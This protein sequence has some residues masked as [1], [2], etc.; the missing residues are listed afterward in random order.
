M[1]GGQDSY[2]FLKRIPLIYVPFAFNAQKRKKEMLN[3]SSKNV[4]EIVPFTLRRRKTGARRWRRGGN[5]I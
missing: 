2:M 5:R 3:C 4:S 1:C